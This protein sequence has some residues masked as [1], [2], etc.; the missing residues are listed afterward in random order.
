MILTY[1]GHSMFTLTLEN[2][3]T[4]LT[5]PYGDFYQYPKHRLT[6]DVITVSHHHHDHD[7]VEMVE[8][9]PQIFDQAGVFVPANDIILTAIPSKHDASNGVQRGDNLI[10]SIETEG[11][12][13]V[14]MGDIGHHLTAR[15]RMSIGTPDVLLIPVGGYYTIDAA[16]AADTV[17]LLRPRVTIPMH[18]STIYSA[19]TPIEDEKPFLT[20]MNANPKPMPICRLSF[21]DM[22]E[23][24]SVILMDIT[25]TSAA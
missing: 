18:Y 9:H 13:I 11:L 16:A 7:A 23:R 20:L 6:A 3:M 12:K 2:G 14:H 17:R 24:P 4:I 1:Y 25:T 8:G 10:F 21:G 15:Q 19:G 5:D 22:S